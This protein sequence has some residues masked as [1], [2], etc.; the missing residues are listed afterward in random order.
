MSITRLFNTPIEVVRTTGVERD[1]IGGIASE[2]TTTTTVYGWL[3][4][5][6]SEEDRANRET[7]MASWV[8]YVPPETDVTGWD[9]MMAL[10]HTFNVDGPPKPFDHPVTGPLYIEIPLREVL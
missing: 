8:A 7:Q 2:T 9:G 3:E 6:R 10:G 4:P 5:T 1:S